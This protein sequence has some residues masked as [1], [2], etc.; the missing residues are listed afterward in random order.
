MIIY[1]LKTFLNLLPSSA[2]DLDIRVKKIFGS[3]NFG[4]KKNWGK[5]F[6]GQKIFGLKKFLGLKTIFSQKN[7]G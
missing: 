7:F 2:I 4:V 3:K 5:K 6:L 1:F